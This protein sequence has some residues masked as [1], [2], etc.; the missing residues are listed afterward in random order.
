MVLVVLSVIFKGSES[1]DLQCDFIP[2]RNS[3]SVDVSGNLCGVSGLKISST[4]DTIT[5]VNGQ[6]VPLTDVNIVHIFHQQINYF[7]K[8]LDKFFPN[9][10]AIQLSYTPLKSIKQADVKPF[11]SK[12]KKF[13]LGGNQIED[14]DS[15]LFEFNSEL[16][17]IGF[18]ENQLKTVGKNILKPLTK[19][20]RAYFDD[21]KCIKKAALNANELPGLVL[22]LEEKC[23]PEEIPE[24]KSIG[25]EIKNFFSPIVDLFTESDFQ[26]ARPKLEVEESA[27][28]KN[29]VKEVIEKVNSEDAPEEIKETPENETTAPALINGSNRPELKE[30]WQIFLLASATFIFLLS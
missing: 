30:F 26:T 2:V 20:Q 23:K 6:S 12:L 7:P 19:L 16:R 25:N 8:G 5:S 9:L 10:E 28:L 27:T 1:I 22:E 14:L 17:W 24:E 29:V 13:I 3:M 15:D 21:N 18:Q 11:G 4:D